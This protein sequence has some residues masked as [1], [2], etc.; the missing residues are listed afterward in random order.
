MIFCVPRPQKRYEG[1]SVC[2]PR[3]CDEVGSSFHCTCGCGHNVGDPAL[4]AK[5]CTLTS[6]ADNSNS[7]ITAAKF[8]RRNYSGGT[9]TLEGQRAELQ[10]QYDDGGMTS[11]VIQQRIYDS[12]ITS[13]DIQRRM[14]AC[15]EYK[16]ASCTGR[17]GVMCRRNNR[18][19]R[20]VFQAEMVR[21]LPLQ[22]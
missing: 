12:G 5:A 2:N 10:Q 7:G 4:V 19:N 18:C 20:G 3:Q 1:R 21:A 22:Q 9:A 8:K 6:D 16:I 15:L 13:A 17:G 14:I 11:A